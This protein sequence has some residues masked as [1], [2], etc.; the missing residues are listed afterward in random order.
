MKNLE[1]LYAIHITKSS[2]SYQQ[3]LHF[4]CLI[5]FLQTAVIYDVCLCVY[6]CVR[7]HACL[8]MCVFMCVHLCIC[9]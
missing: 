3:K 7:L 1:L 6:E 4:F 5:H 8:C 2:P 9:L